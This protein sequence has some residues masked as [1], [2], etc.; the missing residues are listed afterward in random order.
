M[1]VSK[2]NVVIALLALVSISPILSALLMNKFG[3]SSIFLAIKDLFLLFAI[4]TGMLLGFRKEA[5]LLIWSM[6]P[7][8]LYL[9]I[10][11]LLSPVDMF[12]KIAA[13]RQA[14]TPFILIL[15]G[16]L[17]TKNY[18]D[19]RRVAKGM[20]SIL[21]V[22]VIFG[23]FE[24]FSHFWLN[25]ILVEFFL[26]KDIPVYPNGY[27]F[28]FLEPMSF[29]ELPG[30]SGVVRMVSFILD[31]INYGHYLVSALFLMK[32]LDLSKRKNLIYSSTIIASILM[33]FS[34]GAMLQYLIVVFTLNYKIPL[35]ARIGGTILIVFAL[36]LIMSDHAGFLLH[37][38]GL[39]SSISTISVF[40]FGLA[41]VGNYA[42]M[43]GDVDS[44]VISDSFVGSMLGQFGILGFLLWLTPFT[45]VISTAWKS[46]VFAK[47]FLAQLLVCSLSENA[48]NFSSIIISAFMLGAEY[49]LANRKEN[50]IHEYR[51]N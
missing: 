48:L 19:I 25:G 41:T 31:P 46:G 6:I 32:Y 35:I 2:S 42:V 14:V 38:G 43:Y 24:R 49:S 51:N 22:I 20:G 47:V 18:S 16:V 12:A 15:F 33:T 40:G 37:L 23:F 10:S 1:R 26:A 27:P 9:F 17:V 50:A 36:F 44:T 29:M 21:L 45:Y 4:F 3:P 8:I 5:R 11:L 39:T 7:F 13:S 34:K 30:L 28:I